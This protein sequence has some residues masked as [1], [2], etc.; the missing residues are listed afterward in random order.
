MVILVSDD[1]QS[2]A[3]FLDGAIAQGLGQRTGMPLGT[4]RVERWA[5]AVAVTWLADT[6]GGASAALMR[7]ALDETCGS[8]S[9]GDLHVDVVALGQLVGLGAAEV[10]VPDKSALSPTLSRTAGEGAKSV[11]VAH[12]SS[13]EAVAAEIPTSR[14]LPL[15]AL[16]GLHASHRQA[17]LDAAEVA[18]SS[19][20]TSSSTPNLA[21]SDVPGARLQ[22][23]S[24][25]QANRPVDGSPST[26]HAEQL[27]SLIESCCSRLWVSEGGGAVPQGVMLDLGRWMP[28]CTI[29]VAKA[30]GVLRITM[31][32]LDESRRGAVAQELGSLGEALSNKLGCRV[33]AA[34]ETQKEPL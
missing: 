26:P 29:E 12:T 10:D 33:V 27:Q 5:R 28:G 6:A 1:F 31:R 34:I 14:A 19:Q 23:A 20:A 18:L 16:R 11:V 4:E 25:G 7:D 17:K 32:G 9:L 2:V 13:E 30:A 24:T 8:G 22:E 15:S 3:A 21:P